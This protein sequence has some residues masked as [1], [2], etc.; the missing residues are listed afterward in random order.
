[1]GKTPGNLILGY[2]G[3]LWTAEDIALL[4][5]LPDREVAQRLG[6]S[7]QSVTQKRIKLVPFPRLSFSEVMD[8][9]GT[10]HPDLR[11][12]LP[13]VEISDLARAGNFGVFQSALAANGMVKGIRVPGAGGYSRKEIEELTEFAR[14]LGA[15]GLVS[16]AI[17][18]IGEVKSPLIKFMSREE[19]QAIIDRL[20]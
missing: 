20:Q 3:P 7:L 8:R 15:K 11:F 19:V 1:M 4:G 2:H 18:P 12:D 10:D 17:G 5:T 14:M 9:Y 16:L 6:R 13:L